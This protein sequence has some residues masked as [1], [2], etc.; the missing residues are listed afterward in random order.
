VSDRDDGRFGFFRGTACVAVAALVA[1]C[2]TMNAAEPPPVPA[3]PCTRAV[4]VASDTVVISAGVCNPWCIHVAAPTPVYFINN[5]PTLYFF[6][7]DPALPYDVQ[8]PGNAG[9]VT[10]PLTAVGPVTWT[11]AHQPAAT[12]TIF[13][14]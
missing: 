14:E 1:A 10:L 2:G 12:V 5:D 8:V 9:A 3:G 6:T 11:A 7:A 13:V 4:A